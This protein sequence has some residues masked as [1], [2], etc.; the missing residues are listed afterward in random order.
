MLLNLIFFIILLFFINFFSGKIINNLYRLFFLI[1][2]NK[3]NSLNLLSF[4]L[5]PGTVIHELAHTITA[6]V[7]W[8]KTGRLS[9][10]PEAI[11]NQL[12]IGQ[13]QVQK[14]DFLRRSLIGLAPL[15]IGLAI[16]SL[17]TNLY[18]FPQVWP[19]DKIIKL[20]W[21][22]IVLIIISGYFIF[23]ISLTMFSSKKDLETAIIPL[24]ILFLLGLALWLLGFR[25]TIPQNLT[26][27]LGKILG[28]IDLGLLLVLG[29]N[30]IFF[31]AIRI[32]LVLFK[33]IV[34]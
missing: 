33:K 20:N 2:Q 24:S 29:L 16:I 14:T 19:L 4:W 12:K 26:I 11:E 9:F 25:L 17:L 31:V 1:S 5:L 28:K 21:S 13:V 34:K 32:L 7:L 8:V 27:F 6:E 18:L 3:I 23:L 30:L 10:T 15:I 22:Q